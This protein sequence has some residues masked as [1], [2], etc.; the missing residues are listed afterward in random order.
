MVTGL[1]EP[2]GKV[3]GQRLLVAASGVFIQ[4]TAGD[5]QTRRA[6]RQRLRAPR[7]FCM[8][9]WR[10]DHGRDKK[11]SVSQ[12]MHKCMSWKQLLNKAEPEYIFPDNKSNQMEYDCLLRRQ[13]TIKEYLISTYF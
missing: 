11:V 10:Q 3:S 12:K 6:H 9:C 4:L 2:A 1:I 7:K 13:S 5:R 8:V